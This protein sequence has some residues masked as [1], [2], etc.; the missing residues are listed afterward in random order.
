MTRA[1]AAPVLLATALALAGTP[2]RA[3]DLPSS[4]DPGQIP[5]YRV[6]QPN[7]ATGGRPAPET[8]AKL[9]ELGFKTVV[10]LRTEAEGTAAERAAVEAQGLRYVSV[11]ITAQTFSLSDVEAVERVLTDPASG[12][13]LLHCASS[14]RV[15]AVWAVIQ[16]RKGKSLAEAEAAGRQ[17]GMQPS[18]QAAVRRV[19]GAPA[20]AG[21]AVPP[22]AP[23]P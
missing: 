18:M 2:S 13:T 3:G 14:N 20:D 6:I 12:P 16:A 22:P 9:K 8:V 4:V 15:G 23:K 7:L 17:A 5:A 19:L 11:P 10:D 21:P 1:A